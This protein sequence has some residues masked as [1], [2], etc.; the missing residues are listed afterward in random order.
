MLLVCQSVAKASGGC[1]IFGVSLVNVMAVVNVD[2]LT[3]SSSSSSN[4]IICVVVIVIII[5]Y[6]PRS[7]LFMCAD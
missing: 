3:I 6:M 4:V 1:G 5:V 2:I 7:P